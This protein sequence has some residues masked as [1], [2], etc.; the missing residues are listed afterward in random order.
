MPII[1]VI[2]FLMM[3]DFYLITDK[4]LFFFRKKAVSNIRCLAAGRTLLL[5]DDRPG[6]FGMVSGITIIKVINIQLIK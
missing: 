4:F 1:Q 6:R 2:I 5:F 3:N